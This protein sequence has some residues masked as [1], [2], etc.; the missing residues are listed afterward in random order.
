MQAVPPALHLTAFG[1]AA[2]EVLHDPPLHMPIGVRMPLAHAA[3]PHAVP[4][5]TC[6]QAP[7][8]SHLPSLPQADA[9]H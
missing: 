5:V 4:A 1:Q 8:P 6:S 9:V 7:L 3:L 2:P